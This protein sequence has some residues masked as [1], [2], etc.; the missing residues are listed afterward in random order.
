MVAH[1]PLFTPPDVP[2]ESSRATVTANDV[3]HA[4]KAFVKFTLMLR[5]NITDDTGNLMFAM[6]VPDGCRLNSRDVRL[7]LT[8]GPNQANDAKLDKA[9]KP[10]Y[11]LYPPSCW[12]SDSSQ[13][14]AAFG[15][16]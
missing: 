5:G 7:P 15:E 8:D 6:L 2:W 11:P 3:S 10:G 12:S 16:T 14:S 4:D 1:H 9:R 13:C